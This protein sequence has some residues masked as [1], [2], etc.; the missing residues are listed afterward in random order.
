[1]ILLLLAQIRSLALYVWRDALRDRGIQGLLTSGILMFFASILL[2]NMAVGGKD[3]V[4]QNAGMWILGVWGL[5]T[6][7]YL[8]FNLIRQEFQR[9]TA[10]LIL[11]RPVGRSAFL[12]GKFVGMLLVL[13][14]VYAVLCIVFWIHLKWAGVPWN[15]TYLTALVFI[16]AEWILTAALS[17]FFAV[18]TSPALHLFFLTGIVF[19]GH[20]L[21]DLLLFAQRVEN[22]LVHTLLIWAYNA[23][24]NLEALNFRQAAL[25]AEAIPGYMIGLAAMSWAA[26]V[27]GLLL[28][29]HV[30]FLRRRLL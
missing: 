6:V 24:P 7:A 28:A 10:Y 5:I 15:T 9:Q 1:M 26:W 18:V 4:L 27:A 23:L 20:W 30:V 22:P 11:Y 13:M 12:M 25:Y 2:G 19:L 21:Q 8:G 16:A 29:A 14:A 3:R 17:L